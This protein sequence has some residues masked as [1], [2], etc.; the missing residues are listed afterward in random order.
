MCFFI[1]QQKPN[2]VLLSYMIIHFIVTHTATMDT[3]NTSIKKRLLDRVNHQIEKKII[4]VRTCSCP[5]CNDYG[6]EGR[7]CTRCP[8]NISSYYSGKII[9]DNEIDESNRIM[10]EEDL[11]DNDLEYAVDALNLVNQTRKVITN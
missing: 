2:E 6:I 4:I 1:P 8:E 11:F 7:K 5:F 3:M 10:E 9:T